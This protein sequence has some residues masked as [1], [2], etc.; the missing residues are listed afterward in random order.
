MLEVATEAEME[1]EMVIMI[2]TRLVVWRV[3]PVVDD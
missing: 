3:C 1:L 2:M